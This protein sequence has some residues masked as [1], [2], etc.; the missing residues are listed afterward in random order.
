MS[1]TTVLVEI[2]R[3]AMVSLSSSINVTQFLTFTTIFWNQT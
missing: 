1:L 3:Y 2:Q